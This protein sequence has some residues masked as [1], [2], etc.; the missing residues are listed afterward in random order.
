[1]DKFQQ[2]DQLK[3]QRDV[4]G[5]IKAFQQDSDLLMRAALALG[6]LGDQRAVEPL[7]AALTQKLFSPQV[8]AI[9]N[10]LAKLLTP[11][12]AHQA[13]ALAEDCRTRSQLAS[14]PTTQQ[15]VKAFVDQHQVVA[16]IP[17]EVSAWGDLGG[18]FHAAP[19]IGCLPVALI[20][21]GIAMIVICLY[22]FLVEGDVFHGLLGLCLGLGAI[23]GAVAAITRPGA[24]K[25]LWFMAFDQGF[26]HILGDEVDAVR[27]ERMQRAW[28]ERDDF[29]VLAKLLGQQFKLYLER[30]DGKV[31]TL[32]VPPEAE[33][34]ESFIIFRK[35]VVLDTPRCIRRQ[36]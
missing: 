2:V 27:W 18:G 9:E 29:G 15:S 6:E 7:K 4:E 21:I 14:R 11:A 24:R 1:V 28:W 12:E 34:L 20:V 32:Y 36:P 35:R 22:G 25:G 33:K 26:V 19:G 10:A 30:D 3:D 23:G 16:P 13:H 31:Y 8:D 17:P 5:L